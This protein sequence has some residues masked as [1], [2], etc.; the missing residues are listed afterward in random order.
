MVLSQT[1]LSQTCLL[2]MSLLLSSAALGDAIG[3]APTSCPPGHD[4]V[5]NH[6]GSYC[7]PPLPTNCSA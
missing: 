1:R 7:S 6:R 2:L 4:P 3:P 5:S